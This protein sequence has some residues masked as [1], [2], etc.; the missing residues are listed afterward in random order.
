[1]GDT[2]FL[3]IDNI[4]Y[5]GGGY[6]G[7]ISRGYGINE[8]LL[9]NPNL[10]WEIATKYNIG[11]DFQLLKDISVAIDVFKEDRSQILLQRRSIPTWQ[12]MPLGNIPRVNMGE[13]DN[14]GYEVE[15]SYNKQINNDLAVQVKGNFAYNR[16][17]RL[18]VD[19][20][21]RDETY[22][23]QTRET[24]FSIGQ[25]WGYVIDWSQDGGYWTPEALDDPNRV[26]YDF[27]SP[28]PG[29][30]VYVD[31]NGD[32]VISDKDQAPI[33]YSNIPRI[34]WGAS[35]NVE[36]KGFDAYVF[37]QGLGK[38]TSTFS[39]QGTYETTSR[40]TYFDYHRTAW[41]EERWRNG[42]KI[43]YPA[44]STGTNVNHR[45][46]S[47]FIFDRSFA[48]FKN[49]EIGYTL[50]SGTLKVLGISKM[51]IF[52]QGQ[53]IFIWSPNFHPTHLDPENDDSIG[54][55]QTKMFSFGT[56]ITF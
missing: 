16:N 4:T 33:G 43:T 38:Y 52:L 54:Y 22:T 34:I 53:N 13:V 26:T 51:R 14:R 42:E 36:Y 3:Y 46:N 8:G 41:T 20:V 24:G 44:L 10:T 47:F 48:R 19:E 31:L 9:G 28:R 25:N 17:K 40:G 55:P 11:V 6:L 45:A 21:P 15:L 7:S 50:P 5:G 18:N 49:A 32:G 23:Y 2:R 12:G 30:F 29:D 56:N 27:G 39:S 35:L 1:M 37:F